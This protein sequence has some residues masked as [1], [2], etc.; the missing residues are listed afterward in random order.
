MVFRA[1]YSDHGL[2]RHGVEKLVYPRVGGVEWSVSAWW[3]IT[4][5]RTKPTPPGNRQLRRSASPWIRP[6]A[7]CDP[8]QRQKGK[9]SRSSCS[10][11]DDDRKTN[12]RCSLCVAEQCSLK[13]NLVFSRNDFIFTEVN[14]EEIW[15]EIC[16][17][18]RTLAPLVSPSTP[19]AGSKSPRTSPFTA[20]DRQ[21]RIWVVEYTAYRQNSRQSGG[22]K[23][24][25][26]PVRCPHTYDA[27]WQRTSVDLVPLPAFLCP[28][29]SRVC[30]PFQHPC[31][32]HATLLSLLMERNGNETRKPGL[33]KKVL[34]H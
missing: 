8:L 15:G 17:R 26:R 22:L 24:A 7:D 23:S 12:T 10:D 25:S 1:W 30:D 21:L 5:S 11:N 16:G 3:R 14:S 13:G 29:T 27:E 18:Q 32:N 9:I 6:V 2:S 20:S 33:K 31:K 19:G 34:I 28:N 4:G